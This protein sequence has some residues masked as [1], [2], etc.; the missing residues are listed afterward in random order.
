MHV[1]LAKTAGFCMGVR[2]AL[3]ITLEVINQKKGKGE[4]IFTYGPLIHNN[5]AVEL[6]R[7]RGVGI[8]KDCSELLKYE[9]LSPC[10]VIIRSHGISPQV[11]KELLEKRTN[12]N[13]CDATCPRVAKVQSIIKKYYDNNYDIIIIG[14]KGHA[15]VL[16]LSGFAD[17]KGFVISSIQEALELPLLKKVCVVGQ[18]TQ[19][20]NFFLEITKILQ[21][22]YKEIEVFD[23]ICDSTSMHQTE[24]KELAHTSDAVIVVGGKNSANTTRL[25]DLSR[26][27]GTPTFHIETARELKYDMLKDFKSVAIT[28]GASTPNWI[29]QDVLE[30]V[31]DI[32]KQKEPFI[33]R[34]FLTLGQNIL[35]SNVFISLGAA[36]LTYT[37]CILQNIR[38]RFLYML[39][40]FL[41]IFSMNVLNQFTEQDISGFNYPGK[42]RFYERYRLHLLISGVLAGIGSLIL[43]VDLGLLLFFMLALATLTGIIY[44]VKI[45]PDNWKFRY[46]RLKD[47]PAS[48]DIFISIAWCMVIVIFPLLG[49]KNDFSYATVMG[50]IFT[51]TLVFVRY[52]LYGIK[53]LQGDRMVGKETLPILMGEKKSIFFIKSLCFFL[54]ASLLLF[55]INGWILNIN[56]Y[57]LIIP[58]FLLI[59]IYYYKK[60]AVTRNLFEFIIDSF[61]MLSGIVSF[62]AQIKL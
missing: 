8:I 49:S 24:L 59:Y 25:A 2:R 27:Q 33:K 53:E 16:G 44:Q 40:S 51:F 21:S 10:T 30:K 47:I 54:F 1:Q 29:V 6:L 34:F 61:F 48:K 19:D 43:A 37:T 35:V 22:K 12:I 26:E 31:K 11:K 57:I 5:Q 56:Y 38:P 3:N 14:D 52:M 4:L 50:L 62:L 46:Q 55:L 18:T 7:S 23:T 20:E 15:E 45:I 17:N 58:S 9:G 36:S 39:L 32:Q 60:I 13:I 42:K 28:A 41:Y